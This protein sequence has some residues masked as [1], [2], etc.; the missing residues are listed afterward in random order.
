MG[1]KDPAI[2]MD[3]GSVERLHLAFGTFPAQLAHSLDDMKDSARPPR[4]PMGQEAAMGV[5]RKRATKRDPAGLHEA[6]RLP[7]TA[8]TQIFEFDQHRDGETVIQHGKANI[9]RSRSGHR[10]SL[11]TGNA[12]ATGG[13]IRGLADEFV[14]MALAATE[15]GHWHL[16]KVAGPVGRGHDNRPTAVRNQGGTNE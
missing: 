1:G 4:V 10:E 8:E 13:Q 2:A 11:G 15:H 7:R 6:P 9:A 14:E 5:H 3:K 12:S 16:A